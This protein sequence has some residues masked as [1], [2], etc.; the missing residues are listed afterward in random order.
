MLQCNSPISDQGNNFFCLRDTTFNL[1][2]RSNMLCGIPFCASTDVS[3]QNNKWDACKLSDDDIAASLKNNQ[4]QGEKL[5][6]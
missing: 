3:G 1:N 5:N 6:R 4:H 2:L